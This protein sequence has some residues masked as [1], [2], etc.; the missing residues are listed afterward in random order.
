[1]SRDHAT[2]PERRMWF[3]R[4]AAA[5]AVWA[6]VTAVAYWRGN[7]PR[8]GLVALF[9]AAGAGTIW[10]FLDASVLHGPTRWTTRAHEP[11]RQPGQDPRLD[12]L[13]RVVGQ[14]LDAKEVGGGLHKHL[15]ALADQRLV[16][17]Y[18][19]SA[20]ADPERAAELMGP[21][22]ARFVA[23]TRP[24]PR[25]TLDQIDVLVSRIEAL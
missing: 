8:P 15:S 14:H 18:G 12:L 20:V 19:V 25:L 16:A 13:T 6:V 7:Q 17:R 23:S 24:Y 10:L 1:M 2:A 9:V 22:L 4:F 3:G 21:E 11:Y 5:F